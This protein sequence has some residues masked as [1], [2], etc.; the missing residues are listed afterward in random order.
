MVRTVDRTHFL[1]YATE[2]AVVLAT[3]LVYRMAAE[4]GKDGLDAYVLAR[5]GI[6]FVQP[7]LLVG[8]AVGLPR[9]VAFT[10]EPGLRRAYLLASL[11]IVLVL[12]TILLMAGAF[13]PTVTAFALLGTKALSTLILPVTMMVLG[14]CLHTVTYSYLRGIQRMDQANYIQ[15]V[16]LVVLPVLLFLVTNDLRALLLWTGVAWC[17][18]PLPWLLPLLWGAPLKLAREQ[19]SALLRYGLPRIPGD[20]A[21]AALLSVPTIW[22]AQR[23]GMDMGGRVGLAITLLN[24]VGAAFAPIS[25]LLLPQAAA[26]L[27]KGEFADLEV[28]IARLERATLLVSSGMLILV[29]STL[30]FFLPVYLKGIDTTPYLT[31]CRGIFLA[32]PALAYFV[33]LRSLLDAYHTSPRNGANLLR[34]FGLT[35]LLLIG[36]HLLRIGGQWT[37]MSVVVGL[38]YLAYLTWREVRHVRA[39]LR[40]RAT[41]ADHPV[42]VVMVIPGLKEGNELPFSRRQAAA[43]RIS[44]MEVTTFFFDGRTSLHGLWKARRAF[45]LCCSEARP[46]VVHAHYGTVTALFTVLFS[47]A[48]V[49]VTF[50]GSDLNPTPT[51]GRIRDIL[52]RLM[53]QVAAFF[54][55]GIICVSK[56]LRDRLWWRRE[57]AQILPMGV[58]LGHFRPMHRDTCRAQLGWPTEGAIILFNGNNPALKRMDIAE[59]VEALL[60]ARGLNVRLQ[61][62]TGS[63]EATR[64]PVLMNA[65]NALL[66]CSDREG[67]P[68]MVK[69]AM[70]CGIP[71]V[72]N[73]VGDVRERTAGVIPGAVVAQDASALAEA[74]HQVLAQG[75]RS[76]GRERAVENGIDAAA[77]DRATF[78]YLH[79]IA[80]R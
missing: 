46:D 6:S 37:G 23:Y 10:S 4:L 18:A 44:G 61:V 78:L 76:N 32:A 65:S 16:V 15:L 14:L 8:L 5:R 72:S 64:M 60:K 70:A 19:R 41:G 42:R 55:S 39:V 63:I 25:L 53:S 30:Q 48:P 62:L 27:G 17:L 1:T 47:P 80:G 24:I 31:I 40:E 12:C 11:R 43:M 74:L 3:L 71:V 26:M 79:R 51:D 57:E 58:D 28:R 67:S 77:I 13:I 2:G 29:L 20:L 36:I 69:E 56:G 49:V 52:G 21:F 7:V 68:T 34:A 38:Y 66:L 33:A 54:A 59:Q 22:A 75:G 73:D 9:M 50:H 45:K 35:C